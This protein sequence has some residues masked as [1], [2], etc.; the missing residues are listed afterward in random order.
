MTNDLTA[1]CHPTDERH[2]AKKSR[3]VKKQ[4]VDKKQQAAKKEVLRLY[5]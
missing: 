2:W 3:V 1:V 5:H 4:T